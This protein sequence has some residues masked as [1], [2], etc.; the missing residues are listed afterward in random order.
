M[1]NK[2]TTVQTA[3]YR[4]I[5][6]LTGG[7]NYW[8]LG[9][10]YGNSLNGFHLGYVERMKSD[11]Q[12][13]LCHN[14]LVAPLACAQ[15]ACHDE[16]DAMKAQIIIKAEDPNCGQ[17]IKK[18]M[19]RFW[20]F[21]LDHVMEDIGAGY[22]SGEGV[23]KIED[24]FLHWDHIK[25][26]SALDVEPYTDEGRLHAVRLKP[27][28]SSGMQGEVVD[29]EAA[30]VDSP[31]KGLW[32]VNNPKM[33][34]IYG[35]SD[36]YA[37]WHDWRVK[38]GM[39]DCVREIVFKA[40]YKHSFSGQVFRYPEGNYVDADGN[41]VN[42]RDDAEQMCELSKAGTNF[43]LSSQV[44][45]SGKYLWS[46]E[47]YGK[48]EVD[49]S[50]LIPIVEMHDKGIR[51]GMGIP[52]EIIDHDGNTGGYSRS[53]VSISAFFMQRQRA[54]ARKVEEFKRQI[55]DQLARANFHNSKYEIEVKL[56]LQ[57]P[58]QAQGGGLLGG[59]PGTPAA[60][61]QFG[62][63]EQYDGIGGVGGTRMSLAA[64]RS[65]EKFGK[66]FSRILKA[67]YE[68]KKATSLS[69]RLAKDSLEG[70]KGDNLSDDSIPKDVLAK[71]VKHEMEHTNDPEI[72]KEIAKDHLAEDIEYYDKLAKI[73]K[74][75]KKDK[76]VAAGCCVYAEDTGRVLMLQR[77]MSDDDPAAGT[78][79]FP[80][81]HIEE[82]EQPWNAAK[83]EW[84]EE[85]GLFLPRGGKKTGDWLASNGVYQGFVY[86]IPKEA[87]LKINSDNKKV[88]NPDD[89]DGD[90]V[91]VVAWYDLEH[92]ADNPAI[93]SELQ[94]DI[95]AVLGLLLK[96]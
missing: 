32:F 58:D 89:P 44:D 72:A 69:T 11:Y 25:P 42:N 40:T 15:I 21:D 66:L 5:G 76:L 46:I 94:Q 16:P 56:L 68:A 41:P 12:V 95:D 28:G 3:R 13:S 82:G 60:M 30:T 61:G 64:N 62:Q 39:P 18:T 93:R 70:G 81:G 38:S 77:A 29:L 88:L 52:D 17:F 6:A 87:S 73:E 92:L 2:L 78:W 57:D 31:G 19:Q 1:N 10:F 24:G 50:R 96:V 49:T 71:A 23:Y 8:G 59:Q 83:R 37:A 36:Y 67:G 51:R 80:G 65:L 84:S 53:R 85:T 14:F 7:A 75:P 20:N 86:T 45:S 55:G 9:G 22:S 4:P 34:L 27:S 90:N 33:S 54:L 91:E 63:P 35:R 48:N 26:M 47:S 43:A 74:Q 79:E